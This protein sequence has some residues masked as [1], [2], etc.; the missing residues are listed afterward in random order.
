MHE[1]ENN[2]CRCETGDSGIS[3]RIAKLRYAG[4][5]VG[6]SKINFEQEILK[7]VLK[8]LDVSDINHT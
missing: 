2:K 6:S 8:G 1:K 3:M 7:F 4:Y 5:L